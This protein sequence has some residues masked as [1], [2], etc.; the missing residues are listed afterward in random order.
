MAQAQAVREPE[1]KEEWA[2]VKAR[3]EAEWEAPLP[4]GRA[5]IVYVQSVEQR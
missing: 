5:E 2:V 3:V 4:P 1:Q